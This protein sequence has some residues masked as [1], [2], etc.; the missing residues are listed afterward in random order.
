MNY[1]NK[2]PIELFPLI[3]NYLNFDIKIKTLNKYFYNL[4]NISLS[5][6]NIKIN[7]LIKKFQKIVYINSRTWI[8]YIT[9]L[10]NTNTLIKHLLIT[11]LDI[12]SWNVIDKTF[13]QNA[14]FIFLNLGLGFYKFLLN[15]I[16]DNIKKSAIVVIKLSSYI[17]NDYLL[18]H[19]NKTSNIIVTIQG[20]LI[21]YSIPTPKDKFL[22]IF[23]T[24]YI[25]MSFYSTELI[26][27]TDID[28][29]FKIIMPYYKKYT[30][31]KL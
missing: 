15:K 10:N 17:T 8:K 2:L 31:L 24:N 7:S 22:C 19:I 27:S 1:F 11:C 29:L 25:T 6:N 13:L 5:Q 16:F 12:N 28:V 14:D 4:Y 9:Y 30:I 18:E 26:S 21:D 3:F 23:L 20:G